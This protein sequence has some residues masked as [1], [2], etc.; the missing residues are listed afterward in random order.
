MD[1][2]LCVRDIGS[3]SARMVGGTLTQL[4]AAR[5]HD[6]GVRGFVSL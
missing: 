6:V 2:K 5:E 3:D 4:N 1:P